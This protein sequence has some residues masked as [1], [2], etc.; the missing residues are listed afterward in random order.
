M[1]GFAAIAEP[2][3]SILLGKQW[4]P[5]VIFFQIISLAMM[6]YPIHAFNINILKV[7]GRSDLFLKLEIIKKIIISIS[8]VVAFQFGVIGLVLSSV[9]TSFTALGVNMFYS[10]KL[11]KY[12]IRKQVLD[13][14]ITFFIAL[15]T[16]F[17]MFKTTSLFSQTTSIIQIIIASL[18]GFTIYIIINY[19]IKNSPLHQVIQIYNT[20]NL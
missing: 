7:Y 1:L 6:L 5:A 4:L 12:P 20:R 14:S 11:I 19:F 18:T 9:F 8:V 13:L 10:S 16:A 17:L 3:F 2:L 15:F